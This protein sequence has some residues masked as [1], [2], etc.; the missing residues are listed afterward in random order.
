M[1]LAETVGARQIDWF[2]PSP[3]RQ[4][5]SVPPLGFIPVI[6]PLMAMLASV[7]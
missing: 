3:S 4:W 1:L 7:L 6:L 2:S 5:F